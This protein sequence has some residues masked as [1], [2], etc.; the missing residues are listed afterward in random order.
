MV[1]PDGKGLGRMRSRSHE[2]AAGV[3][4]EGTRSSV[5]TRVASVAMPAVV[6]LC[7]LL[8]VWAR[9]GRDLNTDGV[10]YIRIAHYLRSG[11][12]DL[13]VSG[14]WGPM[15][16]WLVAPWLGFSSDAVHAGSVAMALSGVVFFVGS[17]ALLRHLVCDRAAAWAGMSLLGL[18]GVAW[19][20]PGVSPDLLVAGFLC[21]GLRG[22][23]ADTWPTRP[24]TQLGAG[25]SL[26]AAY[27]AK[28]AALPVGVLAIAA[29]AT[30]HV[31]RREAPLRRATVGAAVTSA[32][33]LAV[34][35]P[36]IAVLSLHYGR[37]T[38]S[39]SGPI[40]HAIVGPADAGRSHPTFR[41]FHTPQPGRITSWEDPSD[42][43]Y[44][45]WSPVESRAALVHQARVVAWNARRV[46]THLLKFDWVHLGLPAAAWGLY[47]LL[48]RGTREAADRWQWSG[49]A[50][51]CL[52]A[53]YLPVYSNQARYLLAAYPLLLAAGFGAARALAGDR[54]PGGMRLRTGLYAAVALSFLVPA[55]QRLWSILGAPPNAS[56]VVATAL[57]NEIRSAGVT[58]P[59][60]SVGANDQDAPVGLYT[61][62]LLGVPWHGHETWVPTVD[63]AVGS[64]ARVFLV[65]SA[66][67]APPLAEWH[68]RLRP[69]DARVADP[70]APH[71]TF[72]V[73]V[74]P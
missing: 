17:S 59:V 41:T 71:R 55:A 22:L 23:M 42:M 53:I 47:L 67:P 21:L 57:A 4:F 61:A 73:F 64:G 2:G 69:L 18:F 49:V 56:Y 7:S 34:A 66:G 28:A 12:F 51:A 74:C 14:Y 54:Q 6:T 15:L 58:G 26:G 48:R 46:A 70:D 16:S 37:P 31:A 24:L 5:N 3:V 35:A 19:S 27:L 13:A 32:G 30:L 44:R 1:T 11:D 25:T 9:S 50:V 8:T 65:A 29:M 72:Q 38:F 33:L 60:A 43:P 40:N 63:R 36:W 10:A 52:S 62:F 68:R 20:V 45:F 39:T